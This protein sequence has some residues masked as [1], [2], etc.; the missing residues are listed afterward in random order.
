MVGRP[1]AMYGA[2]KGESITRVASPSN[3]QDR[4]GART[5]KGLPSPPAR[6][7]GRAERAKLRPIDTPRRHWPAAVRLPNPKARGRS[8]GE[9]PGQAL[10]GKP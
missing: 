7:A 5:L 10:A 9:I 8:L 6:L 1:A 3:A 2:A 4:C